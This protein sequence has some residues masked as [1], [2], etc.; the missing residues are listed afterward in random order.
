M[1]NLCHESPG[2][3]VETFSEMNH[4]LRLFLP[5]P[6]SPPLFRRYQ[7]CIATLSTASLSL[8]ILYRHSVFNKLLVPLIPS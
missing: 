6:L 1:S 8:F 2:G 4:S 5:S 3:L 7:I